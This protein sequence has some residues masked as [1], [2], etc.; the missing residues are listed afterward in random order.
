MPTDKPRYRVTITLTKEEYDAIRY[1]ANLN[2]TTMAKVCAWPIEAAMPQLRNIAEVMKWADTRVEQERQDVIE[3]L[4]RAENALLDAI[5]DVDPTIDQLRKM[6]VPIAKP[7]PRTCNTGVH[8][9]K[10]GG[11][12]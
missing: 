12:K 7:D 5:K 3:G 8:S 9:P 6:G 4:R 1:I 2:E 11:L 10:A